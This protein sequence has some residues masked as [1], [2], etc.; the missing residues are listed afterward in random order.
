MICVTSCVLFVIVYGFVTAG[1][2]AKTVLRN[3]V[4]KIF[5]QIVRIFCHDLTDVS[6]PRLTPLMHVHVRTHTKQLTNRTHQ[7]SFQ[8]FEGMVYQIQSTWCHNYFSQNHNS[9][10]VNLVVNYSRLDFNSII[11]NINDSNKVHIS[12]N[13]NKTI[14]PQLLKTLIIMIKT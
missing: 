12:W 10:T 5:L 8:Y 1:S 7:I 9:S 4:D 13:K 2:Y 6:C 3:G 14:L 11:K